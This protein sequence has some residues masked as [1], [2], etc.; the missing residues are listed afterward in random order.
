MRRV[1]PFLLAAALAGCSANP[2][3]PPAPTAPAQ[4]YER[5]QHLAQWL[6][7]LAPSGPRQDCLAS[8]HQKEMRI[9]DNSTILFRDSP[10]HVWVQ[11]TQSACSPL[12]GPGPYALLTR[13]TIS[14][15]CSGDIAQVVETGSGMIVGSCVIGEFQPYSRPR[16]H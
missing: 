5:D 1:T 15:L 16:P 13:S 10:G 14:S 8:Y 3:S 4:S 6:N 12:A 7:G 9:I 11:K 2:T